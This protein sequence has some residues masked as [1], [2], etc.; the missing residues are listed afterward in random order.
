MIVLAL[1]IVACLC[2]W[3]IMIF[4][5]EDRVVVRVMGL[6]GTMGLLVVVMAVFKLEVW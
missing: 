6:L 1:L 5:R 3:L 4:H 2:D